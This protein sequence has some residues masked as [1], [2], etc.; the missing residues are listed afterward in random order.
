M[1]FA[2]TRRMLVRSFGTVGMVCLAVALGAL[3]LF[4]FFYLKAN[5]RQAAR[6]QRLNA[7]EHE[8]RSLHRGDL[9][10]G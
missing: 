2:H 8:M 10:R 9:D 3:I 5:E 4:G 1:D 6:E 7:T